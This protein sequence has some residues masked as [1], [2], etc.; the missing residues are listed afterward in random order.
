[1]SAEKPIVGFVSPPAWFD[2]SPE[3]FATLTGGAVRTQQAIA[4]VHD[5]NYELLASILAALPEVL[6]AARMLG[7]TGAACVCMT[8][9]PF[10]WVGCSSEVE[11]RARNNLVTTVAGCPAV[12]VGPAIVD[13]LRAL[14]VKRIAVCA[15][16][17]TQSWRD[18]TTG[19]LQAC[20]FAISSIASAEQLGLAAA[21]ARIADHEVVSGA[22]T[23][24]RSLERIR[25]TCLDAEALVVTGASAR[26]L[27]LIQSLEADLGL[28]VIASDSALY[29]QLCL[30]LGLPVP[31]Q[32]GKLAKA[33]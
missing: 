32:L 31:M 29:W 18:M 11:M 28:P 6:V 27:A 22:E 19:I 26:T 25:E 8:G 24:R 33:G 14:G 30:A 9:T 3:E 15:P 21:G 7:Q 13:A 1:M 10:G 16:Y 17:Y 2:P 4:S 23:L 20:G 12:L 5:L